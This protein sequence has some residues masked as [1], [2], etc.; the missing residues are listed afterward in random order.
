MNMAKTIPAN[1]NPEKRLFVYLITRD[2]SLADAILDLIDNSLN[3]A[4]QP[5]AA[6]LQTADDYQRFMTDNKR[7]PTVDIEITVGTARI[8]VR[9]AGPGIS[10]RAAETDIFRFGRGESTTHGSDR[11]SVLALA[12]SG[13]C[14]SVVIRL[15]LFLITRREVLS[16]N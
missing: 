5:L 6:Q 3:A 10:A 16:L 4:L 11:L 2:I 13:K 15:I 8:L 1:A 12:S 9:D 7:K 14:L